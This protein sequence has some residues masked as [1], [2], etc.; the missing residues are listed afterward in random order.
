MIVNLTGYHDYF[1]SSMQ[2]LEIT[3]GEVVVLKFIVLFSPRELSTREKKIQFPSFGNIRKRFVYYQPGKVQVL[4][5][6]KQ[7]YLREEPSHYFIRSHGTS[8]RN[9]GNAQNAKGLRSMLH[10]LTGLNLGG[11]L[12]YQPDVR[13]F[14]C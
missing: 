3:A 11:D 6:S 9:A 1:L 7:L 10:L 8:W 14:Y 5:N 13:V 2:R 12:L 4:P